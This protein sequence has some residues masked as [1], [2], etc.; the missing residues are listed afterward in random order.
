MKTKNKAREY[1]SPLIDALFAEITPAE[2]ELTGKKMQL[3]AK[4]DDAIKAKG[5]TKKQFAEK[6]GKHPS[7]I[8]KWLSGTHNFNLET[9]FDIERV[10]DIVLVNVSD[11]SKEITTKFELNISQISEIKNVFSYYEISDWQPLS[12]QNKDKRKSNT[13]EKIYETKA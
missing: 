6:L 13:M 12:I 7:E 3:A 2:F 8:S 11:S 4:I 1:S 9:L 5:W 10:L